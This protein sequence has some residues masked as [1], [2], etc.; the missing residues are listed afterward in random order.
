MRSLYCDDT[1]I[2]VCSKTKIHFS[3]AEPHKGSSGPVQQGT[4]TID[5]GLAPAPTGCRALGHSQEPQR[6]WPWRRTAREGAGTD[7]DEAWAQL[8][9]AL[10]EAGEP[11]AAPTLQVSISPQR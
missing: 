7:E 6:A 2:G 5:L 8:E 9:A 10:G 1:E 4:G 11:W 3:R